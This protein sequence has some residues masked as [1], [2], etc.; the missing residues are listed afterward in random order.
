MKGYST[1]PKAPAALESP[2]E[3]NYSH[4]RTLVDEVLLLSRDTVDRF[5]STSCLAEYFFTM[6]ISRVPI[7]IYIYIYTLK[8]ESKVLQYLNM[9]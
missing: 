5:C 4:N 9:R 8:G 7:Y 1:F 2:C 3:N 6:E